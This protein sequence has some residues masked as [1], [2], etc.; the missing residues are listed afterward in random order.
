[1]FVTL[2]GRFALARVNANEFG[3]VAFGHLGVAPEMQVAGDGVAAPDDDQLG[4]GKK[5]HPHAHLGAQGVHQT[6]AASGVAQMVRF[7][8]DAPSW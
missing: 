8:W 6:L 3:T 4:L 2:V 5:L 1:V 7:S